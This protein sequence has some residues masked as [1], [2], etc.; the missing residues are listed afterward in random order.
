M[1]TLVRRAGVASVALAA[2]MAVAAY[3]ADKATD[4]AT[5]KAKAAQAVAL[6]QGH[7]I[8]ITTNDVQG[9]ALRMPDNLRAEVL[10]KPALIKQMASNLYVYRSIAQQAKAQGLDQQPQVAAAMQAAQDKVL[11]DAWLVHLD[12]KSRPSVEAAEAKARSIY[13]AEPQKFQTPEQ[14]HARHILVSGTD[15][16]ARAKAE[17]LLKALQGGA[18]FAELATKESADKGSAAR[19]GDLGFFARGKMVAPFEEAAF[20]MTKSG[21]L[22]GLV[23]SQFGFHIIR[24]EERRAAGVM[25]F[26]QVREALL[27]EVNSG[28]TQQARA[29]EAAKLRKNGVVDEQAVEA[30]AKQQSAPVKP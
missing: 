6:V 3:A 8:A 14:V 12:G 18:D 15:A 30:F 11:A 23:E 1:K 29:D 21:Q 17:E 4:K 19:G 16:Q 5:D 10:A 28:V 13:Q 2:S 26:E 24:F 22:S 25:P 27:Q 7:G 20:A 9:D